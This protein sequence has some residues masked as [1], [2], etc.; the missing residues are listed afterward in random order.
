MKSFILLVTVVLLASTN[1]HGQSQRSDS[2]EIRGLLHAFLEGVSNNDLS[3]H[4]W[5]WADDLIYTSSTGER[6]TKEAILNSSRQDTPPSE[7]ATTK[8]RSKDIRLQLYGNTAVL[9]FQ[10]IGVVESIAQTQVMNFLNSGTLLKR[11]GKWQVVNW[12]STRMAE[13]AN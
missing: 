3:V 10:L 1:L 4:E 9:A 12:Q 13:T 5:F 6:T 7:I 8:Y 2:L 11:D